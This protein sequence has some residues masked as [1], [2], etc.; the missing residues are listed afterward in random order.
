MHL[1][2]F[3]LCYIAFLVIFHQSIRK[4]H[5]KAVK[6]AKIALSEIE[7]SVLSNHNH[8]SI[9]YNDSAIH[10]NGSRMS[11]KIRGFCFYFTRNLKRLFIH[12][13]F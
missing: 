7:E 10:S 8:S 6:Q 3:S 4:Q 5:K 9:G 1:T 12:Q 2:I 11:I 13:I